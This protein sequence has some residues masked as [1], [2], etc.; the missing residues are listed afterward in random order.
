MILVVIP[1]RGGS[2]GI[3]KK[4]IKSLNN[5]PLIYYTIEAA[6]SCF[7]DD[8]ICV[9][10][11]SEEIIDVVEKTGLRV[12]FIRPSELATDTAT[13]ESMLRHAI[14]FYESKGQIVEHVVLLQPTSPLR[15]GE[16][17]KQAL[18]LYMKSNKDVEML[19]SVKKTDA[20]PYYVL[21][22]E[23]SMGYL[24]KCMQ[25]T[26]TRRQDLPAVYEYNGA[27][28]IYNV[29]ALKQKALID[30]QN[31]IKFEMDNKYS[32]DID[33]PLDWK[34]IEFLLNQENDI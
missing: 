6:R 26:S 3:P 13:S 11:D 24:E 32:A 16:H 29:K 2:K 20:N 19:A 33:D 8:Q 14:N 31:I 4:N 12:P 34:W 9:S 23:N 25:S 10:T 18:S 27:I 17:I 5:K 30:F 15:N 28:Y 1:A 22:E 21:V 7:N